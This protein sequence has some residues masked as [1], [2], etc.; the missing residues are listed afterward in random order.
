[1][2]TI[3]NTV[4]LLPQSKAIMHLLRRLPDKHPKKGYLENQLHRKSAGERGESKLQKKFN[5][6]YLEDDY[7]ALWDIELK[8]DNWKT[9]FDGL[10]LTK[11]CVI[12]LD[13]KNVSD[14]L[15]YDKE[16]DEFIKV[17]PAG[18]RLVLENPIY[19]LNKNIRFLTRWLQKKKIEIKVTGLIVYTANNCVFHSKPSGALLCKTYQMNDTLYKILQSYPQDST[20]LKINKIKKVIE[21]NHSPYVRKPLCDLYQINYKDLIKGVYCEACNNYQMLRNKRNWI[22]GD[23]NYKNPAAHHLALQEYF[24]LVNTSIT[25]KDLCSF[26]I[27]DSPATARRIL[28]QYNFKTYGINK[29]RTYELN[30]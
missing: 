20:S 4:E 13:S 5:E 16:T 9:Q 1:M 6:F 22:C 3:K 14:D 25:N 19:Q 30:E 23:C 29:A 18:N 7:A 12:I 15:H 8:L 21:D 17:N 10:I 28:V 11:K 26:C 27:L 2:G 24:S